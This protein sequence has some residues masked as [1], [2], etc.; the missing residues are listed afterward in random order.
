MVFVFATSKNLKIPQGIYLCT[1]YEEGEIFRLIMFMVV[2]D[3]IH[4]LEVHHQGWPHLGLPD[5]WDFHFVEMTPEVQI[6]LVVGGFV[7]CKEVTLL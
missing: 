1:D 5:V 3:K 4:Y 2:P 6:W 7:D